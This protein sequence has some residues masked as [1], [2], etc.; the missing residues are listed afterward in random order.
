MSIYYGD[1][2]YSELDFD[3]LR[4][5]FFMVMKKSAKT[6]AQLARESGVSKQVLHLWATSAQ[7]GMYPSNAYKLINYIEAKEKD[8]G[9]E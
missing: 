8:L 7:R 1:K 4:K 9:L 5:R 3:E 6:Y 2:M